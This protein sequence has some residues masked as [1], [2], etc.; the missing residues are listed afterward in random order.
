MN[1]G[2]G[3]R[4]RLIFGAVLLAQ[5][6]LASPSR[7]QETNTSDLGSFRLGMSFVEA[8]AVEPRAKWSETLS[9]YTGKPV[10]LDGKGALKLGGLKFD[11]SLKPLA[12]GGYR[13][14]FVRF[15]EGGVGSEQKCFAMFAAAAQ[16]L[17][18]R[19]GE[20]GP[21]R[22]LTED[23]VGGLP[24]G[25]GALSYADIS[26][27]DPGGQGVET[28][29]SDDT[30]TSMWLGGR[31]HEGVSVVV[32][33]QYFGRA[34]PIAPRFSCV[35]GGRLRSVPPR[36]AFEVVDLSRLPAP[37]AP[38]LPSRRRSFTGL[39]PLPSSA[40]DVEVVCDVRRE[41]GHV[42]NCKATQDL[43]G[44]LATAAERQGNTLLVDASALDPDRDI[45]L[46][47]RLTLRID[48]ADAKPFAPPAGM[49][50]LKANEVTWLHQPTG[51]EIARFYPER[52]VRMDL[53]ARITILVRIGADG[54]LT[55]MD[56]NVWAGG[57]EATFDGWCDRVAGLYSAS[58]T[59][60]DGQPSEG[61][62]VSLSYNLALR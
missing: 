26:L 12:Y 40:A 48:P 3:R 9:R 20:L 47:L 54:G 52:A 36:P 38:S 2:R 15:V 24:V 17:E 18:S 8:R 14:D 42:S 45:P 21:M 51:A 23:E 16:A 59:L 22:P 7:A 39:Q 43:A 37:L 19:F 58:P 41:W 6:L 32:G 62:W 49:T 29:H 50:P 1:C 60:V 5:V 27:P 31:R 46:R 4:W 57:Q 11:I 56:E 33:G 53:S 10:E 25:F 61:R 30:S 55:C 35:V 44:P 13:I 28:F 34:S